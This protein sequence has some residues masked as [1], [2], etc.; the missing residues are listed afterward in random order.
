MEEKITIE[1]VERLNVQPGDVLLVT[2]PSGT[3]PERAKDVLNRFETRL[4]VRV[5]VKT[6]DIQVQVVPEES[7]A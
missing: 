4:P 3:T 5:I 7:V 1:D 6:A 2:V